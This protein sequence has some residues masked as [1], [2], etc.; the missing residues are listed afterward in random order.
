MATPPLA[1]SLALAKARGDDPARCGFEL[2]RHILLG[3]KDARAHRPDLCLKYGEYLLRTHSSS[4]SHEVWAAYEQVYVALLQ[5]ARCTA[6]AAAAG[7]SV[8]GEDMHKA[9]EFLS[10]L[11]AQFPDSLRVKRL[12]GMMSESKGDYD[13]AMADYD[14]IL[15]EDPSN[16]L[17][18]KRQVSSSH[19]RD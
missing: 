1:E 15:A 14:D 17:A 8:E 12:E 5:K 4:L 2:S 18:I 3:I 11:S 6:R 7:N 10:K 13:R 9:Q 19:G 16:L